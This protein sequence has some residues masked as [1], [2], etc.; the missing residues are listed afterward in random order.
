MVWNDKNTSIPWKIL[1]LSNKFDNF[2]TKFEKFEMN[3][4]RNIFRFQRKIEIVF[5]SYPLLQFSASG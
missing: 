5:Y 3:D 4:K 2:K 1:V